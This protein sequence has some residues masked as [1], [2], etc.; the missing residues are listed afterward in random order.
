MGLQEERKLMR[1]FDAVYFYE[2]IIIRSTTVSRLDF[3]F[4]HQSAVSAS[5]PPSL[6]FAH[7][8]TDYMRCRVLHSARH[9]YRRQ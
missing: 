6:L 9:G 7:S 3:F 1:S 4:H 8:Y 5:K 2:M